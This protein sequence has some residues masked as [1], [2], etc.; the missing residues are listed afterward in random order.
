MTEKNAPK[1]ASDAWKSSA[2]IN[3]WQSVSEWVA[4]R[5][6]PRNHSG[7][8]GSFVDHALRKGSNFSPLAEFWRPCSEVLEFI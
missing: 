4:E 5:K 3:Q 2:R 8:R 1:S 7:C 6:E